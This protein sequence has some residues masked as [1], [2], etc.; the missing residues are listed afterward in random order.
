MPK[1]EHD[2]DNCPTVKY[3]VRQLI[4]NKILNFQESKPNVHQ[5]PLPEH[6]A[7]NTIQG[8]EEIIRYNDEDEYEAKLKASR[9]GNARFRKKKLLKG[10]IIDNLR[11]DSGKYN[12]QVKYT[13]PPWA[14]K[15]EVIVPDSW[16]SMDDK[17]NHENEIPFKNEID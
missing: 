10:E 1:R 13:P 6:N 11:E 15:N 17:L 16:A 8:E 2:L 5:N 12:F 4:N 14:F 7:I 3:K 9:L